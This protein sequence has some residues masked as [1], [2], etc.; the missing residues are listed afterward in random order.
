MFNKRCNTTIYTTY[1]SYIDPKFSY[2][3]YTVSTELVLN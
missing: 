1:V 3:L 2:L